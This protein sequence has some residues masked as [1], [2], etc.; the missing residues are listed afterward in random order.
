MKCL[1]KIENDLGRD[2]GIKGRSARWKEERR[3]GGV[4]KEMPMDKN[5]RADSQNYS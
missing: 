5:T 2:R 3:T 4:N 1:P